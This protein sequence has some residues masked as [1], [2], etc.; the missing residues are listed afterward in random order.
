M[1][2]LSI[3]FFTFLIGCTDQVI[4]RTRNVVIMP[5]D[6]IMV[7]N[8]IELPNS[9]NLTDIQVARLIA[10]LYNENMT[11]NASMAAIRQYLERARQETQQQ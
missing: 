9:R 8:I 3:I 5:P 4:T 1:R 7:C 10:Q 11:C 6:N 2:L